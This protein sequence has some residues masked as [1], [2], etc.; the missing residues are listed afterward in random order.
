MKTWIIA[1]TILGILIIGS[2]VLVQAISDNTETEQKQP[3]SNYPICGGGCSE[4]KI[5]GNPTCGIEK[6]GSC[7]CGK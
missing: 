1:I 7:S 3:I 5:C 2:F 6:T 4:G